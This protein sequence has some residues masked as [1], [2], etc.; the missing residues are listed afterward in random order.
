MATAAITGTQPTAIAAAKH[1]VGAGG[2][3]WGT[4]VA[5]GIDRGDARLSEDEMRRVH[6]PPFRAA[7]Q[8]GVQAIMVSYSEWQGT[9]MCISSHWLT[10][11]I[12]GELGFDGILMTDGGGVLLVGP[13]IHADV[14]QAVTAGI[15]L[16]NVAAPYREV[17]SALV[18][19][20]QS[21]EV[22]MSR[23]DDAVR[24][25]LR[26]KLRSG[27]FDAPPPDEVTAAQVGSAAHRDIARQAVRESLVLLKNDSG[28]LPLPKGAR[29]H[30]AGPGGA[31]LGIQSGGWTLAWQGRTGVSPQAMGGGTSILDAMRATASSADLVTYSRDGT[32]AAGAD[33]G[34]VVLHE[35]PYAEFLGD[36]PNPRFDNPGSPNVYDGQA[37]ARV[38]VMRASKVPLVLLLLTG[39]PVRIESYLPDFDAVVAAWLPGSEG[40]GVADVLYGDAP[41]VGRLSRSWPRDSATLPLTLDDVPYNPL[42]PYGFGLS[43]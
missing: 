38:G 37:A 9:R 3:T 31:D 29:V 30:V 43:R 16:V 12:K 26:V 39:R 14:L 23:I 35:L 24:R 13:D 11:V 21:G 33:V 2:T 32:G 4:G 20:V 17:L 19:M 42:F 34:V 22:P 41:F 25:I 10:D 36:T 27:L 15:D 40:Q 6:L 28:L 5:G 18:S 8:A 1:A 7:V